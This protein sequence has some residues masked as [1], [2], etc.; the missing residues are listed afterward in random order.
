MTILSSLLMNR[1][2]VYGCNQNF[3]RNPHWR[4]LG[5]FV[6]EENLLGSLLSEQ[7]QEHD[8]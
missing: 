6:P 2:V 1:R 4:Q 7:S 3:V 8:W 5:Y